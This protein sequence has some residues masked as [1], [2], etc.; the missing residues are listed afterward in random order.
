M[1]GAIDFAKNFLAGITDTGGQDSI[2]RKL[3]RSGAAYSDGDGNVYVPLVDAAGNDT[4][5]YQVFT[6]QNGRYV[7]NP[8][9]S[10]AANNA[11]SSR[12]LFPEEQRQLQLNN[13]LLERQL[14]TNPNLTTVENKADGHT[15]LIDSQTGNLVR[16]LGQFGYA[17]VDPRQAAAQEQANLAAQMQNQQAQFAAN[18]GQQAAQL[19]ESS[20]ANRMQE[21]L[22]QQRLVQEAANAETNYLLNESQQIQEILRNP[23]DF[24]AR[25]FFQR[26][27]NSPLPQ[28]TQADLINRLQQNRPRFDVGAPPAMP[29]FNLP[30][31][32]QFV[33]PQTVPTTAPQSPTITPQVAAGNAPAAPQAAAGGGGGG[34]SSGGGGAAPTASS[35]SI[36][37]TPTATTPTSTPSALA[38]SPQPSAAATTLPS[39]TSP[40]TTSVHPSDYPLF[41]PNDFSQRIANDYAQA[42]AGKG[43]F[44]NLSPTNS[45][46]TTIPQPPSYF[47]GFASGGTTS[48]GRFIV[49]DS[50]DGRP[51]GNEEMILNPTHAPLAVVSNDDL[52]GSS[53]PHYATGGIM[54]T[55]ATNALE[56]YNYLVN[57]LGADP[58][59]AAITA[60]NFYQQALADSARTAQP[61][62]APQKPTS[63]S[64]TTPKAAPATTQVSPAPTLPGQAYRSDETLFGNRQSG[65]TPT[66]PGGTIGA[67]NPTTNVY[68]P[69]YVD[70]SIWNIMPIPVGVGGTATTAGRFVRGFGGLPSR[71]A[72]SIVP[73]T[74]N[75]LERYALPMMQDIGISAREQ[76]GRT[77]ANK[78]AAEA[79]ATLAKAQKGGYAGWLKKSGP[80]AELAHSLGIPGFA[81]G[82]LDFADP[83]TNFVW[84]PTTNNWSAGA[85]ATPGTGTVDYGQ[86]V[87]PTP[88]PQQ[89]QQPR[90]QPQQP[91]YN[92]Q[93]DQYLAAIQQQL[94]AINAWHP[95][96]PTFTGQAAPA[97]TAQADI[98]SKA[99]QTSGP[100]VNQ[101]LTTGNTAGLHPLTFNFPVPSP[102]SVARLT[103]A[104]Q[105]ALNT[106]LAAE[107][108]TT[109]EDVIAAQKQ[110]FGSNA[111]PRARFSRL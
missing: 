50:P 10:R 31:L 70:P 32:P 83:N 39:Y 56:L 105:N 3:L 91:T 23:A 95:Q 66:Y 26:G 110:R 43:G 13:Q 57:T 96:M 28:V 62:T 88:Q 2:I 55:G 12:F 18:Y 45:Y 72:E 68:D 94:A 6:Q 82:T 75:G 102:T 38:L 98:I 24:V 109:L 93:F 7:L 8:A 78:I 77:A 1:P 9:A 80:V 17:Q 27:A 104:E 35:G 16:D 63:S 25:A 65:P 37:A 46:Y 74:G 111:L 52:A 99:Q 64:A 59:A 19:A 44:L 101:L 30:P 85:A 4:G 92:T 81:A 73:Q 40:V 107:F 79:E 89:P 67:A 103:P 36:A 71:L 34:T 97:P 15:Y 47:P 106:R 51:T 108:N 42:A 100:A 86:Q 84:N 53:L 87:A 41:A 90:L 61:T 49:G 54:N 20:R 60:N 22:N 29:S 76:A 48:I 14:A 69:R 58:T 33:M 21:Y 5:H 11:G